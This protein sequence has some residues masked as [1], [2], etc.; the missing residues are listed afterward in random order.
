[1]EFNSFVDQKQL[2]A[3]MKE[4][5]ESLDKNGNKKEAA[6]DQDNILMMDGFKLIK[7]LFVEKE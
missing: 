2:E 1:M 6:N 4:D 3:E 5:N 7:K